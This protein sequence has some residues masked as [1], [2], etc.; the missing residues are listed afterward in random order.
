MDWHSQNYADL[1]LWDML[2]GTFHNPRR[3][4][5]QCGF[6]DH[7]ERRLGEMIRWIDIQ[8]ENKEVAKP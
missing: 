7:G 8:T 4:A 5:E 6:A 2:F 3:F 1:P